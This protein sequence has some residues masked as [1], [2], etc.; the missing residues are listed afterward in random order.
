MGTTKLKLWKDALA[1]LGQAS[2]T[3]TGEA[4]VAPASLAENYDRTVLYC[5]EQGNWNFAVDTAALATQG[6]VAMYG[7]TFPYQKPALWLRT[8]QISGSQFYWPPSEDY[9]DAKNQINS[10]TAP[11]YMAF[12][13]AETATEGGTT[14]ATW[15]ESFSTYVSCELA[16]RICRRIGGARDEYEKMEERCKAARADALA[17]DA[18]GEPI[19]YPPE[20][21]WVISRGGGRRGDRGNR[22]SLTG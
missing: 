11:L 3:A 22:G 9:E 6:G 2:I 14:K 7:Y 15:P 16:K 19:R 1:E 18:I 5:L 4:G 8:V 20:G 12:V 13:S 17:K 21:R 10:N